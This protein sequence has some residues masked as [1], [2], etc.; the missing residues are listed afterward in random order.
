MVSSGVQGSLRSPG[1]SKGSR[2]T[3]AV[4]G[5]LRGPG[6]SMGSREI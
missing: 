4:Q 5:N 3:E 6:R 2:G 1:K